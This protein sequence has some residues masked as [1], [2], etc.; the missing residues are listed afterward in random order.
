MRGVATEQIVLDPGPDFGKR[1]AQTVEALQ[2]LDL[3]HELGRPL[4][5]AISR[6]DFV[7]AITARPPRERLAGTLAALAYGVQSGAHIVRVHDV[8]EARDFLD[9]LE[10]LR[11]TRELDDATLLDEALRRETGEG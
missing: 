11:G 1:P 9:V 4:L 2:R 6:K 10:T 5:L 3:L 7:G 8:R